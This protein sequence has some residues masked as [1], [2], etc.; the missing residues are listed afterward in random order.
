MLNKKWI[1]FL[2]LLLLLLPLIGMFI[3][4]EIKWSIFDFLIMG[5][6][7]LSLSFS[8]KLLLN[9]TKKLKYRIVGIGMI[10]FVF[11]LIWAELAV[12]IFDTPFAGN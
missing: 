1:V 6:L 4:D 9:T 7:I 10:L 3:S 11:I 2:P 5:V 8:I 12:G